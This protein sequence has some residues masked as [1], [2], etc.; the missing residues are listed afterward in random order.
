ME[1]GEIT[2][3]VVDEVKLHLG[4]AGVVKQGRFDVVYFLAEQRSSFRSD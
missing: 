4:D 2:F 1:D 3:E